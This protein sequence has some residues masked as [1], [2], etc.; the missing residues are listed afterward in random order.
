MRSISDFTVAPRSRSATTKAEQTTAVAQSIIQE[1]VS[2]RDKKTA[3]LRE[4]RLAMAEKTA[5]E[6]KAAPTRAKRA[7]RKKPAAS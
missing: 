7:R 5:G 6:V 3:R 4:M 1:E 2:A